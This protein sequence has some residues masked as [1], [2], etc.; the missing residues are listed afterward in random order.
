MGAPQGKS[1]RRLRATFGWPWLA[2]RRPEEAGPWRAGGRQRFCPRRRS[3]DSDGD[4]RPGYV[5]LVR[6]CAG[7]W[8]LGGVWYGAEGRFD[9]ELELD[10]AMVAAGRLGCA[11]RE[12]CVGKKNKGEGKEE[13]DALA[14]QGWPGSLGRRQAATRAGEGE[15]RGAGSGID[16]QRCRHGV[17]AERSSGGGVRR[18]RGSAAVQAGAQQGGAIMAEAASRL[19]AGR[20]D[21][22]VLG[23]ALGKQGSRAEEGEREVR[24]GVERERESQRF[25]LGFSQNFQW[26]LEKV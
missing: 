19:R 25:D 2:G 6:W 26:K 18:S 20:A 24:K 10:A 1:K 12:L 3:A 14:R 21:R 11:S 8:D 22:G 15:G 17:V 7:G 5:A 4:D 13:W 16:G 23:S 9:C